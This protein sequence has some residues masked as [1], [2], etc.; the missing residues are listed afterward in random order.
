MCAGC[1]VLEPWVWFLLT[2]K[3]YFPDNIIFIE[4]QVNS[5]ICNFY[6][7]LWGINGTKCTAVDLTIWID[8]KFITVN[9]LSS[10]YFVK[11]KKS[12]ES[13]PKLLTIGRHRARSNSWRW[14]HHHGT[15]TCHMAN[16]RSR[17]FIPSTLRRWFYRSRLDASFCQCRTAVLVGLLERYVQKVWLKWDSNPRPRRDQSLNLAP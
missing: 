3:Y 17:G 14:L 5:V 11:L 4:F 8:I 1:N 13:I 16:W 12:S 15:C 7:T 6:L 9:I 2:V 10:Y